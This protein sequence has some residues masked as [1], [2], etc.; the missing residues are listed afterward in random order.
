MPRIQRRRGGFTL[1]ELMISIAIIGSLAAIGIP[2]FQ[3]FQMR[4]RAGEGRTNLAAIRTAEESYFAEFQT[5]IGA[6][7][8]PPLPSGVSSQSWPLGTPFDQLGFEPEGS[9]YF[10]YAVN[11]GNAGGGL[12]FTADAASDLDGDLTP[13]LW[14]V[15]KVDRVGNGLPGLLG[16]PATGVWDT[17]TGTNSIFDTL[18]ACDASSGSS[19]F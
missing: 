10:Q 14:G 16:C 1:I 17:T 12:V 5:Y 18:G 4:A 3:R 2:S 8:N 7:P 11:Q 19:V 13:A 9:V 6:G 15:V